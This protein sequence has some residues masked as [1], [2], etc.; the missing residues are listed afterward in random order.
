MRDVTKFAKK[1]A[2]LETRAY[3]G[4]HGL[5]LSGNSPD[6]EQIAAGVWNECYQQAVY[7]QEQDREATEERHSSLATST[8]KRRMT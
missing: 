6:H 5:D 8:T 3:V 7:E 1:R 4:S 2:D